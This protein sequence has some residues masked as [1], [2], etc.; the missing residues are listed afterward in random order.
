MI[1]KISLFV[2]FAAFGVPV[3]A[4][5]NV[6]L[7]IADD[8]GTDYLGFYD[9]GLDTAK[10][11]HV[12]SLLAKGVRFRRAWSFPYCSEIRAAVLTGRYPFRTGV[13]TVI[14]D[15][16][17]TQLDTA[18]LSIGKVIKRSVSKHY[19][20]A[21]IGKWHLHTQSAATRNYPAVLGYDHYAGN[22]SGALQDFFDWQ[23]IVD[24]APSVR[25]T[26]Y[27]TTEQ[28][29]DALDWLESLPPGKPF[30]L[31]QAFNA[32]HSPY[33]L[34]PATLH[35]VTGLTG[36]AQHIQ[37]NRPRYFK[38]MI[39]AMDTEIG[40]LLQWLDTHHL[41]DSTNIIFIGDN[42]TASSVCQWPDPQRSKGT[43]YE[44]GVH[45]P[46]IISGPAISAPGRT[47]D[48]LASTTDLFAT[49][50]EMTGISDWKSHIP[51][52]K[53]VD[54]VSLLAILKNTKTA[55]RDWVFTEV[56]TNTPTS[57]DAKAIRD[58]DFKLTRFDNGREEFYHL[59]ADPNE[60]NNLLQGTLSADARAHYQFLC[61]ALSDLL[62]SPHCTSS[63][64]TEILENAGAAVAVF[65]NPTTGTFSVKINTVD[66]PA[67][68][69]LYLYDMQGRL[70]YHQ[71]NTGTS[72]EIGDL[73]KGLYLLKIGFEQGEVCRKVVVQ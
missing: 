62:A 72:G 6:V 19:A 58:T 1:K 17:D 25:V 35:S 47:S 12:R 57:A 3:F 51:A 65:P 41:R 34:P 66:A 32:P 30:F 50:L 11:P 55:V 14:D 53:P 27:A 10:M 49:I 68:Q 59:S 67:I 21:N 18:E 28:T 16:S 20:T 7:I 23:K 15:P 22:F 71:E 48:A 69:R 43:V 52:A 54:A 24:G 9:D 56:F 46:L 8:L 38:A 64:G 33:H 4:Q 37:Q 61:R 13:G 44:A 60:Q 2:W 73:A 29:D 36:T 42:G 40:R 5:Q 39:E 26:H 70:V 63:V 31:W 45:V